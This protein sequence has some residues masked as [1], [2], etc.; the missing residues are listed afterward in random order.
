MAFNFIKS[1]LIYFIRARQLITVCLKI[2]G[3]NYLGLT[4]KESA[5]FLGV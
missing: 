5:C 2:L 3:E 4:P 1:E